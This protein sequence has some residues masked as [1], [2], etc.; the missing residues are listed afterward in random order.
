MA[1]LVQQPDVANTQVSQLQAIEQPAKGSSLSDFIVRAVPLALGVV[2]TLQE[3][4]KQHNLALGMNDELNQ[5]TREVS[6]LD[7]KY[8]EQGRDIQTIQTAM[9]GMDNDVAQ[10]LYQRISD[11]PDLSEEEALSEYYERNTTAIN[12]IFESKTLD[13]DTKAKMYEAQ[14]Q[15][16]AQQIKTVKET[17]KQVGLE[18]EVKGR[19]SRADSFASAILTDGDVTD[20][21]LAFGRLVTSSEAAYAR[22]QDLNPEQRHQAIQAEVKAN[23]KAAISLLR[24]N[25][26]LKDSDNIRLVERLKQS[27]QTQ[28]S[29]QGIDGVDYSTWV[30][31]DGDIKQLQDDLAKQSEDNF[32][33]QR[34][35]D[36]TD[37][38]AGVVEYTADQFNTAVTKIKAA[39]DSGQIT[40]STATRLINQETSL[41]TKANA[42]KLG[43]EDAEYTGADIVNGN[44]SVQDFNYLIG[45]PL[46]STEEYNK[47]VS[48][49]YKE[50]YGNTPEGRAQAA[51]A[52]IKHSDEGGGRENNPALRRLGS[53]LLWGGLTQYLTNPSS[54]NDDQFKRAEAYWA[55]LQEQYNGYMKSQPTRVDDLLGADTLTESQRMMMG[56][57]LRDGGSL[58]RAIQ[59]FQRSDDFKGNVDAYRTSVNS[60]NTKTTGIT[61]FWGNGTLMGQRQSFAGNLFADLKGVPNAAS[62]DDIVNTTLKF[63]KDVFSQSDYKLAEQFGVLDGERAIQVGAKYG[64]VIPSQSRYNAAIVNINA[65]NTLNSNSA[66]PEGVRGVYSSKAIDAMIYQYSRQHN[67]EAS[68]VFVTTRDRNGMYL[69]FQHLTKDGVLND[70]PRPVPIS[71]VVSKA[72]SIYRTAREDAVSPKVTRDVVGGVNPARE[73]YGFVTKP[74]KKETYTYTPNKPIGKMQL[75]ALNAKHKGQKFNVNVPAQAAAM[76]NGNTALTMYAL[77]HLGIKE[78]FFMEIEDRYDS[79]SGKRSTNGAIQIS[80]SENP[81]YR[82]RIEAAAGKPQELMNIQGDFLKDRYGKLQESAARVGIPIARAN[83][84]YPAQYMHTQVYMLDIN[85]HQGTSPSRVK[86]MEATLTQDTYAEG[87]AKLKQLPAYKSSFSKKK[88]GTLVPTAR[89]IYLERTLDAHYKVRKAYGKR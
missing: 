73:Q 70:E 79:V 37:Y 51:I 2:D 8:Y 5:V 28:L 18:M 54:M 50:T 85:Y 46:D 24:N 53:D 10:N 78:G 55:L 52:M 68:N 72:T 15:A 47:R 84:P 82:K 64:M 3:E 19:N 14:L 71:T 76:Y 30:E 42:A 7:R 87:L 29:L 23:L 61:S 11:N 44:M 38:D 22:R 58:K 21:Q 80:V 12:A 20:G 60:W 57:V 6:W 83:Q 89:T 36:N 88:D 16:H 75:T 63:T 33:L 1:T 34:T 32:V 40:A 67:I 86:A 9:V 4:S 62:R 35:L 74:S 77:Q 49:Y 43:A 56:R 31:A 69:Y 25:T 48:H 13:S 26:E 59:D 41:Y 27:V 81:D 39:L 45:K 17:Y 66:I 65:A